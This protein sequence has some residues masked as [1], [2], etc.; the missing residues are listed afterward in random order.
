MGLLRGRLC[1][2][3]GGGRRAHLGSPHPPRRAPLSRGHAPF[4][5]WTWEGRSLRAFYYKSPVGQR[6]HYI[7]DVCPPVTEATGHAGVG[8]HS[9]RSR[10]LACVLGGGPG[11]SQSF[12][13][14]HACR[15]GAELRLRVV[16]GLC[17]CDPCCSLETPS[18][19]DPQGELGVLD[20][21]LVV[22]LRPLRVREQRIGDGVLGLLPGH[23]LTSRSCIWRVLPAKVPPGGRTHG[24][25]QCGEGG[26]HG[27]YSHRR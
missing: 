7:P 26:Q 18:P 12:W 21:V 13:R 25:G 8:R 22:L 16:R 24:H 14:V 20:V 19:G 15:H 3:R 23:P 4:T 5:A 10:M 9:P 2:G 1:G 6:G 17:R 11:R 27:H